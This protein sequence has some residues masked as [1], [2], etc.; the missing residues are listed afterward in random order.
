[1]SMHV[2]GVCCG[3]VDCITAPQV[4]NILV[5]D[6]GSLLSAGPLQRRICICFEQALWGWQL[7]ARQWQHALVGC[8]FG[9]QQ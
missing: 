4:H 2:P 3:A 5:E 9:M 8:M 7:V 1:M 6:S